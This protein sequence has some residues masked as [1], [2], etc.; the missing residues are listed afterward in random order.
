MGP[1]RTCEQQGT[2]SEPRHPHSNREPDRVVTF[3]F[4]TLVLFQVDTYPEDQNN[5][6]KKAHWKD[7]REIF[8]SLYASRN[9]KTQQM[10]AE[11]YA[12]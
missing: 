12:N 7:P 1:G 10:K 5:E 6:N 9:S 11:R 4:I 3:L 2:C 8:F